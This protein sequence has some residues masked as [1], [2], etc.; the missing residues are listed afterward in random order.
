MRCYAH[1]ECVSDVVMDPLAIWKWT[2]HNT[3]TTSR[4]YTMNNPYN[5]LAQNERMHVQRVGALW[6]A[7]RAGARH[8]QD[9]CGLCWSYIYSWSKTTF[10]VALTNTHTHTQTR[11]CNSLLLC[12][13]P[14]LFFALSTHKSPTHSHQL[15]LQRHTHPERERERECECDR[16][17]DAHAI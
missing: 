2:A 5:I 7:R 6:V 1:V 8:K 15:H 13:I 14:N 10:I 4:I 3:T 12:H 16:D 17:D 11:N 9:V